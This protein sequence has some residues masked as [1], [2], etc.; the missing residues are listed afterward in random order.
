MRPAVARRFLMGRI[1]HRDQGAPRKPVY[2]HLKSG[3]E[4]GSLH[5]D[6][7]HR[8]SELKNAAMDRPISRMIHVESTADWIEP[9][10]IFNREHSGISGSRMLLRCSICANASPRRKRISK[11]KLSLPQP[12]WLTVPETAQIARRSRDNEIAGVTRRAERS[13]QR[14][15]RARTI[16]R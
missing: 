3:R 1:F 14:D 7:R 8:S 6:E 16:G 4:G 11:S 5:N 9:T 10:R 12:N 13:A 2:I 15:H